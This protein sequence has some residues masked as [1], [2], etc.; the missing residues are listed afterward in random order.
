[1]KFNNY[2]NIAIPVN[3]LVKSKSYSLVMP[4]LFFVKLR[5]HLFSIW[6]LHMNASVLDYMELTS[7]Q[8]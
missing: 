6:S 8:V 4:I 1:L 3:N 2:Q 7:H 5:D